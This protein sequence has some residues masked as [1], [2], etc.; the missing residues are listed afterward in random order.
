MSSELSRKNYHAPN[1][2]EMGKHGD[3]VE[4]TMDTYTGDGS[5]YMTANGGMVL[6]TLP[7]P[8]TS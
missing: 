7:D 4:A 6:L 8:A 3:L 1:L 2:I 5:N